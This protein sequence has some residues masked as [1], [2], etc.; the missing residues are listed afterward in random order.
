[1]E[2]FL[3]SIAGGG[4]DSG[5]SAA[6]SL[7]LRLHLK[8]PSSRRLQQQQQQQQQQNTPP[9]PILI[10]DALQ[11]HIDVVLMGG[12]LE[13]QQQQHVCSKECDMVELAVTYCDFDVKD[14]TAMVSVSVAQQGGGNANKRKTAA[15]HSAAAV[16]SAEETV[17]TGLFV[18]RCSG[19]LHLCGSGFC[20]L[21]VGHGTCED[22]AYACLLTG[23]IVDAGDWIG[24]TWQQD[25]QEKATSE[26]VSWRNDKQQAKR[27]LQSEKLW[28]AQFDALRND[29]TK[30]RD[31]LVGL[32]PGG[33]LN[34]RMQRKVARSA[35]RQCKLQI[36]NLL[37]H[38]N[39]N[40]PSSSSSS[41]AVVPSL[42]RVKEI[43]LGGIAKAYIESCGLQ[44]MC[45]TAPQRRSIAN[46]YTAS[47]FALYNELCSEKW[48]RVKGCGGGGSNNNS[49]HRGGEGEEG[50]G[51][52]G[53]AKSSFSSIAAKHRNL[54]FLQF[55]FNALVLSKTGLRVSSTQV[56]HP[57]AFLRSALPCVHHVMK[58]QALMAQHPTI[59]YMA[60]STKRMLALFKSRKQL[61][62]LSPV[63]ATACAN[64]R[65]E[66]EF[67]AADDGG[68][69][70]GFGGGG[71]AAGGGGRVQRFCL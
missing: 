66:L 35:M 27:E 10:R 58:D 20:D 12:S 19:Q 1:M 40:R 4:C 46:A 29:V 11:R 63:D 28:N 47:I 68:G 62:T 37:K 17:V 52:D 26:H 3:A 48:A 9:F 49:Y 67:T 31:L 14:G 59:R 32:L 41:A 71:C 16:A 34:R 36:Y 5:Q 22:G 13:Q 53:K 64:S 23:W 69:G 60:K 43:M 61:P 38:N 33:T 18:C 51:K 24:R 70:G 50:K 15:V 2:A 45:L 56:V 25:D 57:D 65:V 54:G 30:F 7:Q 55:G 42:C 8:K 44:V 39:N 21:P 6:A